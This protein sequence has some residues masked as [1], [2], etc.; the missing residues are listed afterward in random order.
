MKKYTI[1]SLLITTYF[2]LLP[3]NLFASEPANLSLLKAQA[4]TYYQDGEYFC[5]I[6]KTLYSAQNYLKK[7]IAANS[8]LAKPEQ[9]AIVFDI[10]ETSL[11]NYENLR[12]DGF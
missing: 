7:R 9:L 8:Q 11:S 4:I 5:A 12:S 1:S 10:D 3:S 6:K 2:S